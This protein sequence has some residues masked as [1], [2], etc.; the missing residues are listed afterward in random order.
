MSRP[1]TPDELAEYNRLT[2]LVEVKESL[3]H[4][5]GFPWY[6]WAKEFFDCT[7]PAAFLCAANQVSK[8]ST[9]IRQAIDWATDPKKWPTL[10]PGLMP[11]QKPNQFWYFYPTF[12]VWQ[13]EFETKWEPDFLPRGRLRDDPIYGWKEEYDK[14]QIKK[15]NFNSG[16]TIYCK[17][18]AQKV[19][20]LQSGSVHA[21]FLDEE[22]PVDYMPELQARLRATNGYI[23]AVFTATLG[24]EYWR[25]VMEPK[26][27][28]EEIYPDAYKRS[29]SLYDSQKY[30]GGKPSRWTDA[31]IKQVIAECPTDADVQRRVFG[32]FVKSEGL[33]LESF[34]LERN[35]ISS[36]FQ[37]PKS[38]S[39]FGA[40]DPGTGGKSGH[41]SAILFVAVQPDH[42]LGV[43]FRAWRGDGIVTANT[44][45]LAKYRELRSGLLP[46][47]QVYDYKEK[48]FE[49]EASSAGE[50]FLPA[51]KQRDEG[52]GLLNSLFKNGMLKI[53]RGDPEI[54]KL[55]VE[56]QTLSSTVDKRKAKDDLVD[57]L[58]Y[59]SM[60]VPWDFTGVTT[61]DAEIKK[62]DDEPPDTRSAE[63]R[64]RDE[65]RAQRRE[66]ILNRRKP[67]SEIDAEFNYWN[68]LAGNDD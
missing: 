18:Y 11:G 53:K 42:K 64:G 31:R 47:A 68:E 39:V 13:T 12:E 52:F 17:A 7:K 38:W 61:S 28:D 6:P 3:P 25:R 41:P 22:C 58:R 67:T 37:V 1:L 49:I 2:E 55:V 30:L 56:I 33:K 48:D 54:E 46:L 40:V 21:L 60:E 45:T 65:L 14:G 62:F 66:F 44:D 24:Q 59:A 35:S 27:R 43:V 19:K 16:V 50:T 29:I 10:W 26:S 32:R 57:C 15:I 8:S 9:Q 5:F 36:D 20:D 4:L 51:K 63:Q 34:D 23:R